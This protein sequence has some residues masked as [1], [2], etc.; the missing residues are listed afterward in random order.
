MQCLVVYDIPDDGKR[1]RIADICLDYGLDRIQYSTFV[2]VLSASY[3]AELQLKLRQTLGKVPGTIL[4]LG[5]CQRDW[6]QRCE[7]VVEA[8]AAAEVKQGAVE[9][10][11]EAQAT[12]GALREGTDA[13]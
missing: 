6:E 2:G 4:L 3:Q 8:G 11:E 13:G 12:K 7:I 10:A 9:A 1:G 5:I